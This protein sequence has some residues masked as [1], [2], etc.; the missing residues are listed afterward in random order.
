MKDLI[1]SC[2]ENKVKNI[3]FIKIDKGKI[4]ISNLLGECVKELWG[5]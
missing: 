5:E 2:V 4:D 3:D 1:F